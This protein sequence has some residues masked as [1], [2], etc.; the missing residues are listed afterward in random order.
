MHQSAISVYRHRSRQYP[1][2]YHSLRLANPHGCQAA[3]SA[4]AENWPGRNLHHRVSVSIL[5]NRLN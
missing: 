5:L 1:V 3:N 2:G 4:N